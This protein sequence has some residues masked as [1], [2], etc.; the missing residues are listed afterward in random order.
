MW[1]YC[2]ANK[3]VCAYACVR[4]CMCGCVYVCA[5]MCLCARVCV[6]EMEV[7]VDR[8]VQY[9]GREGRLQTDG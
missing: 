7:F 3:S 1:T 8:F 9:A 5:C 2:V 6:V 4:V